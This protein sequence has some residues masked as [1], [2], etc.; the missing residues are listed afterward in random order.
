MRLEAYLPWSSRPGRRQ[1]YD[2]EHGV[3][4]CLTQSLPSLLEESFRQLES[5][6]ASPATTPAN[7]KHRRQETSA[8]E[9]PSIRRS[10]GKCRTHRRLRRRQNS[11]VLRRGSGFG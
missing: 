10:E 3:A 8:E 9:T 6:G 1:E 4:T 11:W 5:R 7:K 2:P